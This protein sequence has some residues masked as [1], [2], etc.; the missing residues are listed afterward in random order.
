MSTRLPPLDLLDDAATDAGNACPECGYKPN[1]RTVVVSAVTGLLNSARVGDWVVC[2]A[3]AGLSRWA[4][5]GKLRAVPASELDELTAH[6]RKQLHK[7]QVMARR[8][9]RRIRARN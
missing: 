6:G 1:P 9:I 7:A 4:E 5:G 8:R 2:L 3:C